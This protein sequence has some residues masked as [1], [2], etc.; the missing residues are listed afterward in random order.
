MRVGK[1][2]GRPAAFADAQWNPDRVL[3]HRGHILWNADPPGV[4][5][6]A[7]PNGT[8]KPTV[9]IATLL[10]TL[11]GDDLFFVDRQSWLKKAPAAGGAPLDLAKLDHVP[12]D[13]AI[14]DAFVYV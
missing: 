7:P 6:H 4:V 10:P 1:N 9:S 3:V 13:L 2:G 11:R 12:N 8:P 14:D 5:L